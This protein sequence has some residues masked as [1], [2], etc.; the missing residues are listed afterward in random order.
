MKDEPAYHRADVLWR[1]TYDRVILLS[2]T[3]GEFIALKGTGCTLWDA[4]EESG[5][6]SVL[7]QRL[8]AAYGAEVDAVAA[9]IAPV[10]EQLRRGGAVV[11]RDRSR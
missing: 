10:I 1:R 2:P 8:A 3:T 6:I 11:A 9:D 5:S 7:A 4:L